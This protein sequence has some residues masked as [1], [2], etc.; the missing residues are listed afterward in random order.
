MD[1]RA[2]SIGG[3][4]T[5]ALAWA[6]L[7]AFP[8]G[9]IEVIDNVAPSAHS[10]TRRIDMWPQTLGLPGL[11]GG[12]L[13]SVL[14][15][16]TEGRR[17]FAE[18][19]RPRAAAWGAVSGLLVGALVVWVLGW[20]PSDPWQPAAGVAGLATLFGALSGAASVGA[21]RYAARKRLS[22]AAGAEG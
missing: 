13:F 16:I 7:W 4:V 5:M 14:L 12:G 11:I 20:E 8:G 18:V 22:A 1:T 19:S 10:L 3:A 21:F 17:R 2:A 15:L 6:L 9:V